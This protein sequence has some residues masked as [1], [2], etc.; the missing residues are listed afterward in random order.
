[1]LRSLEETERE[2][3]KR[4]ID[5]W[6]FQLIN[7]LGNPLLLFLQRNHTYGRSR[8]TVRRGLSRLV[9]AVLL[10]HILEWAYF[11]EKH[12]KFR[13]DGFSIA[14]RRNSWIRRNSTI[15]PVERVLTPFPI[16]QPFTVSSPAPSYEKI[17]F[18]PMRHHHN[19]SNTAAI[20]WPPPMHMVTSAYRPP[21]RCNS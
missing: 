18:T 8:C 1:M 10:L 7:L 12:L 5:L 9:G 11:L 3:K 2:R 15:P 16:Q 13:C 17:S 21:V 19:R 4:L 20:P 6:F 14:L